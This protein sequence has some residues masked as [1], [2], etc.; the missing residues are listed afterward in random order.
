MR[1]NLDITD[2]WGKLE[3]TGWQDENLSWKEDCY[4]G[5]WSW[6]LELRLSGPDALR[7]LSDL[8]VNG[9]RRYAVGQAKHGV[10]CSHEGKVI[11]DGILLRLGVEQF[12]LQARGPV[13]DW[14]EWSAEV[15]GYRVE[16]VRRHEK[17][18]FQVSGLSALYLM[19]RLAGKPL[20]E[21][22]F[23]RVGEA[24]I[25][26]VPVALLRQGMAGEIGFE[27]QGPLGE[28]ERIRRAVLAAGEA[29]NIRRMGSRTAMINH[30]EG[31]FPTR[32]HDYLPAITGAAERDFWL[33]RY[34]P[35]P[36]GASPEEFESFDSYLK[37]KGS[38][39][40]DD[41]S[42][43]FHSPVELGW[44]NRITF[45][46]DFRGRAALELEVANP[47][48]R[49]VT[50]IWNSE[51]VI[52]VYA[53]LF[54]PGRPY[55]FMDIPRQQWHCDYASK[56]MAGERLCGVA[57]SR[58]YS[59]YFRQMLSHGILDV[60][61]AVPGTELEVIWGDPGSPQK[62]VRAVVAKSPY[63]YDK[64]HTDLTALPESLDQMP[65]DRP[66]D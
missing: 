5:D 42:G 51:D 3:Y 22:R 38:Y 31:C 1:L 15:G 20:R 39:D 56:V 10:F 17:T 16:A 6:L 27:I 33:A 23:M 24:A 13:L 55:D 59:Y 43:W 4:I 21:L 48:R 18:K 41:A 44:S 45:D 53:S 28:A 62:R 36:Q 52:D 37:V 60:D 63:K 34:K 12:E 8:A 46:H 65:S 29:F 50:L 19:E 61:V 54:R 47:K 64:R 26:G 57:T 58:G 7:L 14:I 30:L 25:D 32:T 2:Q 40:P 49:M 35:L 9:F 11:G 66:R